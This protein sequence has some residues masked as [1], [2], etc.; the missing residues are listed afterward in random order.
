M[1]LRRIKRE[2]RMTGEKVE[3]MKEKEEKKKYRKRK[4]KEEGEKTLNRR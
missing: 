2:E 1:W 4:R 3:K